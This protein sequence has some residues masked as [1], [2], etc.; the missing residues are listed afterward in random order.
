[1]R[2]KIVSKVIQKWPYKYYFSMYIYAPSVLNYR[3]LLKI[4]VPKYKTIYIYK[5]LDEIITLFSNISLINTINSQ[6]VGI[7]QVGLRGLKV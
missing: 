1:M 4:I 7:D 6:E 5:F 2:E 3:D